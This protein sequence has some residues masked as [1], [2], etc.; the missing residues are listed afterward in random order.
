MIGVMMVAAER[1]A[2]ESHGP[3][4]YN[5]QLRGGRRGNEYSSAKLGKPG[6]QLGFGDLVE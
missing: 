3:S 6:D 2:G 5:L 4:I 1:D